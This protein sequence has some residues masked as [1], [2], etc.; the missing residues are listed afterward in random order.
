V[1]EIMNKYREADKLTDVEEAQMVYAIYPHWK[2]VQGELWVF[3]NGLWTTDKNVQ[4]KI[5]QDFARGKYQTSINAITNLHRCIPMLC[6]DND[7]FNRLEGSSRGKVLFK[8]GIYDAMADKF[9]TE[10]DPN[11]LF[12]GRIP[13]DYTEYPDTEYMADV[14][15][16]F[17]VDTLGEVQGD[18][19]SKVY[20]TALIGQHQKSF[21]FCVGTDGD[22]GKST[23]TNAF[24]KACPELCGTF[25][26][27]SLVAR[28][29]MMED[30]QRFRWAL[31]LK[32]KRFVFSQEIGD[33]NL[34]GAI[35]K[36]LTGGDPIV[37]RVMG[38]NEVTFTPEFFIS[39]FANDIPNI[40]PYDQSVDNRLA[41]INFKYQFVDNP[42]EHY[43]RKK[44]KHL[45]QEME[46]IAFQKAFIQI[47]LM[48]AKEAKYGITIPDECRNFKDD[49]CQEE[50]T[51]SNLGE[52]LLETFCIGKGFVSNAEIHTWAE[53]NQLGVSQKKLTIEI[54]KAF[55]SAEKASVKNA[56]TKKTERGF[57]GISF[58]EE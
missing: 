34:D 32:D 46:T 8:N 43:H 15:Q 48:K 52:F 45:K 21:L 50:K 58:K 12:F 56:V 23:F 9:S 16:R 13:H 29:T 17:F 49:V 55:P 22:N 36:R 53:E 18:Y 26:P 10:F 57:K 51:K 24:M 37:G 42:T 11:V 28:Q 39:M 1:E 5:I 6:I 25:N 38:A 41:M 35:L 7:F 47:L 30:A 54:M 3:D 33:G 31:L 19:L 27:N 40:V 44:D 14:Y 4:F 2:Y 20:G